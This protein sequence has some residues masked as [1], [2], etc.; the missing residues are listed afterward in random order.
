[1]DG[2]FEL[3]FIEYITSVITFYM[4]RQHMQHDNVFSL[5][6]ISSS[7]LLKL[8]KMSASVFVA[9]KKP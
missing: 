6:L 4:T 5:K 8:S 7:S 9:N 1:M 3:F 2:N